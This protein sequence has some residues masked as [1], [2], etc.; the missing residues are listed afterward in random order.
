MYMYYKEKINLKNTA[1]IE[2]TYFAPQPQTQLDV[3]QNDLI[4]TIPFIFKS[5]YIYKNYWKKFYIEY[6]ILATKQQNF[7][8]EIIKLESNK[9]ILPADIKVAKLNSLKLQYNNLKN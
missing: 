4:K 5:R 7:M 9:C 2:R 6:R 3:M 1:M 8:L